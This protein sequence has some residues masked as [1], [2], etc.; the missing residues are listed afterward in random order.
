MIKNSYTFGSFQY[1]EVC[2]SSD[3]ENASLSICEVLDSNEITASS[4]CLY[5]QS[6][7]WTYSIVYLPLCLFPSIR[8]DRYSISPGE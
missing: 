7:T 8:L 4:V 6:T 3:V 5:V 2:I 1:L